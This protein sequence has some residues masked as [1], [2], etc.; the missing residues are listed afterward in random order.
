MRLAVRSS[1]VVRVVLMCGPA[2]AGKSTVARRFETD[3][4]VRLSFDEEAW[5]QGHRVHPLPDDVADGVR[6]VVRRR[7]L[8]LVEEG[9]DVVVDSAFWSRASREEY[10]ELL[11]PLGVDPLTCYVATPREVALARVAARGGTGP[12]DLTLPDPVAAS[13]VDT[14]EVPTPEEGPLRVVVGG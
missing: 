2:G 6:D 4:F 11:R 5:S 3:G 10:R 7:L 9:S 1:L 13:Y 8:A 14:F 12:H